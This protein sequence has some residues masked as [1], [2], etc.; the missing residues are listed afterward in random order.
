MEVIPENK[1]HRQE[2][3]WRNIDFMI[4]QENISLRDSNNT[5]PFIHFNTT[6]SGQISEV[7][8]EMK[9]VFFWHFDNFIRNCRLIFT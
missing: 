7:D 3:E 4:M 9:N 2:V 6:E 8:C 5:P 1:F